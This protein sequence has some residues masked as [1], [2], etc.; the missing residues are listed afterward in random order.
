[1]YSILSY[2]PTALLPS[3]ISFARY[4][5]E[6]IFDPLGMASTTYS[7][8]VATT[9][10]QLADGMARQF[11]NT[12]GAPFIPR[13]IPYFLQDGEDGSCKFFAAFFKDE[14]LLNVLAQTHQVL[15]VSLA[16]LS[17]W[18]VQIDSIS[19]LERTQN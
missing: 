8:Q 18:Y 19:R 9:S 5:K 11:T 3:K 13:A 1:M 15:A 14:F 16:A 2:L 10:G 12:G 6:H 7:T 4:V 17:T